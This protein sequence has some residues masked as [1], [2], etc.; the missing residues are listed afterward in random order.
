[1]LSKNHSAIFVAMLT[2]MISGC[3]NV[4]TKMDCKTDFDC[5]HGYSCR[6]TALDS[7]ARQL[8]GKVSECR[9]K[10]SDLTVASPVPT[11]NFSNTS[12]CTNDFD[13]PTG[14]SCRTKPIS[15]SECR[16]KTPVNDAK[17]NTVNVKS[18]E[19]TQ[20]AT[21]ITPPAESVISNLEEIKTQCAKLF[22]PKTDKFGKCV[23]ELTK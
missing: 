2:A 14:Y 4:A 11:T 22:K 7:I 3:T 8:E 9:I 6:T 19:I 1:M 12:N 21:T 13:C 18:P 16:L 23:L 17:T 10:S 20:S 5:A 15:G